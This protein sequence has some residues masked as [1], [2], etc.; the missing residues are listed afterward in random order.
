[1]LFYTRY[2]KSVWTQNS[3]EKATPMNWGPIAHHWQ[4]TLSAPHSVPSNGGSSLV[5][6]DVSPST[7]HQRPAHIKCCQQNGK[8]MLLF[9]F[10]KCQLLLG[11]MGQGFVKSLSCESS[12]IWSDSFPSV[13]FS[14]EKPALN[15][16]TGMYTQKSKPT[17]EWKRNYIFDCSL[18]SPLPSPSK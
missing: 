10:W 16:R 8:E 5:L 14:E 2:A 11:D 7:R 13:L 1:M 4:I 12:S 3:L 17:H 6:Q 18:N 9:F 15:S